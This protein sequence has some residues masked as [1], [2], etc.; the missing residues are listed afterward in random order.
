MAISLQTFLDG[1]E[2]TEYRENDDL[3][4]VTLR[5]VA[6]ERHDVDKIE[7]LNVYAQSKG[8]SVPLKQ[9]SS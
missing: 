2:T 3:I 4:P 6:A 9:R 8:T 5:S 1:L 7:T